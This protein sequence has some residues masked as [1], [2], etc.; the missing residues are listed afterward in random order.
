MLYKVKNLVVLCHKIFY[1]YCG[2]EVQYCIDEFQTW[3][4]RGFA[5]HGKGQMLNNP[6][7]FIHKSGA[8]V[9][10]DLETSS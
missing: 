2:S 7:I 1:K 4:S 5:K 6:N 9:V 8:L 10:V 3:P